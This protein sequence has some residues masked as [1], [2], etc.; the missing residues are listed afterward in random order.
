[1]LL[2]RSVALVVI[3]LLLGACSGADDAPTTEEL[4]V[5]E[6]R[7]ALDE[8]LGDEAPEYTDEEL[9]SYGERACRNLAEI[10]DGQTLK[11]T[12]EAASAGSSDTETLQIAQA[13]V[14]VTTAA[15]HLCPDQGERL[16]MWDEDDSST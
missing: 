4:Y 2:T 13:T 7:S 14:I 10:P 5:T 9:L 16:D 1:M 11:Q 3:G 6:S 15:R 8:L 12:I